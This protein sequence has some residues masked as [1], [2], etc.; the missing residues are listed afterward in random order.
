LAA[1]L[2][3]VRGTHATVRHVPRGLLR[4]LGLVARQ[5]RA[6]L[7]MDTI[8]MTFDATAARATYADLPV[9][10]LRTALTRTV[11]SPLSG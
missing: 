2:Q 1:L 10:D 7:A 8:D 9:T 6:G 3:D 4:V 11:E 5:P